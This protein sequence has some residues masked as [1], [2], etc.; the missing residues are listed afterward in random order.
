MWE[1][2]R[3]PIDGVVLLMGCDKTTPSL[4]MGASSC[5]IPTIGLSGGPMLKGRYKTETLAAAPASGR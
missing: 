1:S 3:H 5:D 4:V 2:I